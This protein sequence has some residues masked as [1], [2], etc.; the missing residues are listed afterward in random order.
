M[1]MKKS[2]TKAHIFGSLNEGQAAGSDH[3]LRRRQAQ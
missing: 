3:D 2:F 1:D